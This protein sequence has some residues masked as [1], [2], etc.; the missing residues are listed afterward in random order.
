MVGLF[1]DFDPVEAIASNRFGVSVKKITRGTLMSFH[2]PHSLSNPPNKIHDTYP[3]IIVTDIWPRYLRGV[4]LHYLNF[5]YVK[6]LL[7]VHG[8]KPSAT[9]SSPYIKGDPN[10]SGGRG[11]AGQ[12][13]GAFRTY[14]RAGIMTP[15]KLD[16]A[17]LKMILSEVRSFAPN[18]IERIRKEIESQIQQRLQ[19]RADELSSFEAAKREA[20]KRSQNFGELRSSLSQSQRRGVDR[21]VE[22]IDQPTTR[23]PREGLIGMG[24]D[25][26]PPAVE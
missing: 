8:E 3:M 11:A 25:T 6:T 16:V 20:I 7:E 4:N 5:H 21:R 17:F 19:A 10:V 26:L 18:E 12:S 2:Y 24:P 14:F 15:K 22:N 23:G 13:A 1:E 9:Y